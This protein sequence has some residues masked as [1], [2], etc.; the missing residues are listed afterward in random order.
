M[1][2]PAHARRR[3][4]CIEVQRSIKIFYRGIFSI[5]IV[6]LANKY[7]EGFFVVYNADTLNNTDIG[8]NLLWTS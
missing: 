8:G 2:L 1:K 7:R 5:F 6:V 3:L 4:Y